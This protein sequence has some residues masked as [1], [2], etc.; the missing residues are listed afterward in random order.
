MPLH[1]KMKQIPKLLQM[2]A[3]MYHSWNSSKSYIAFTWEQIIFFTIYA[4]Y[5]FLQYITILIFSICIFRILYN[6]KLKIGLGLRIH[7]FSYC[8]NNNYFNNIE[9]LTLS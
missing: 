3:L 4:V 2:C 6:H 9:L 8:V 7:S 5:P 1:D